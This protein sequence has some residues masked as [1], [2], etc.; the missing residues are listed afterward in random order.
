LLEPVFT[1]G[2]L[3]VALSRATRVN[4]VFVSAWMA[5]WRPMLFIQNCCNDF[6]SLSITYFSVSMGRNSH[7]QIMGW[8]SLHWMQKWLQRKLC[9]WRVAIENRMFSKFL[10][11]HRTKTVPT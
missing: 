11:S 10:L 6:F 4:D 1:H 8:N 9:S 2:Q 7:I 3:Y 5:G